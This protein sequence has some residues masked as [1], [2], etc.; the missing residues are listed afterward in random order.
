MQIVQERKRARDAAWKRRWE[1]PADPAAYVA[2]ATDLARTGG[3]ASAEHQLRR[4]LALRPGEPQASR[5]LG[6]VERLLDGI[7]ADGQRLVQFPAAP[8]VATAP[9]GVRQK[10]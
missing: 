1:R 3:L 5:L 2:L 7:D 8:A 9:R 10:G 6:R 4:A